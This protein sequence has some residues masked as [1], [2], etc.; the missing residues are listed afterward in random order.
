MNR[1]A[2]ARVYDV[3]IARLLYEIF[4]L[5]DVIRKTHR[6]HRVE[7]LLDDTFLL[8]GR[9]LPSLLLEVAEWLGETIKHEFVELELLAVCFD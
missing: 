5:V 6:T 1:F 4:Q 7:I 9:L 2:L 3:N 8:D